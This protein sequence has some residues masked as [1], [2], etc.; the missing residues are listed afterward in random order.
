VSI[1]ESFEN[2]KKIIDPILALR[3]PRIYGNN[4]EL[5]SPP[6]LP[7][8]LSEIIPNSSYSQRRRR[9]QIGALQIIAQLQ[10]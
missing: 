4:I 3:A 8:K 7:S 1:S 2:S 5:Y 10:A 6:S 9:C